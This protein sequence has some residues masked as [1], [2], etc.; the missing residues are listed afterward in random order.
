M[1]RSLGSID[2]LAKQLV[3]LASPQ[4]LKIVATL[5]SGELHV[6][7][8]ARQLGISR[9]LLYAHLAKLEEAGLL[10]GRIEF[11]TDGK[12]LKFFKV[13]PFQVKF[14]ARTIRELALKG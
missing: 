11:S 12:A 3:A 5:S 4:R 9:P 1:I 7:E 13:A 6:S 2:A 8:L 10:L 14:D